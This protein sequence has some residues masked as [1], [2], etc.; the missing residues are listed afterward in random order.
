MK[1]DTV[2]IQPTRSGYNAWKKGRVLRKVGIRSYEVENN[3]YT[4]IRNRQFLRKSAI[5]EDSD[6]DIDEEPAMPEALIPAA[7]ATNT[8]EPITQL[9]TSG[10]AN[11]DETTETASIAARTRSGRVVKKPTRLGF[12]V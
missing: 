10:T 6:D 5:I 8:T 4:Y 2:R 3:G 12:Q 9:T 11:A 7:T 1:G